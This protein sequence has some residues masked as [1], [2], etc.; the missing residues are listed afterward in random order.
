VHFATELR[1]DFSR[2][3]LPGYDAS[4]FRND[5]C[6]TFELHRDEEPRGGVRFSLVLGESSRHAARYLLT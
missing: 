5:S 6:L 2:A 3:M 1:E 4:G